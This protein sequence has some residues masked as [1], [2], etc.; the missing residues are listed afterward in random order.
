MVS[1]EKYPN[2]SQTC[3]LHQKFK[4]RKQRYIPETFFNHND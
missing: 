4:E 3:V 2:M 1:L